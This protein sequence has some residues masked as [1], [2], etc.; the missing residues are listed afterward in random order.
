[1][2]I[3]KL[4]EELTRLGRYEEGF[5]F[6]IQPIPGDVEVL[7]VVVEDRDELP[8]YISLTDDE[9]ICMAYLFKTNEVKPNKADEMHSVMLT[10]NVAMPLSAFA[11]IDEQ[12]VVF[13]ALSVNSHV[14]EVV[15]EIETLSDNTIESIETMK[16]YLE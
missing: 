4:G 10:M 5:R 14:Q 11:K 6:E 3:N 16:D 13:G 9:I 2:Q 15:H 8:I 12:Y 7:Q 1:V